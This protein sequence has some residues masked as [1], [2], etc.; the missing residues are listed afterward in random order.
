MSAAISLAWSGLTQPADQQAA[1]ARGS[2]PAGR[3]RSAPPG[4]AREPRPGSAAARSPA[5]RA[6]A[7]R[8]PGRASRCRPGG[9]ARGCAAR[10]RGRGARGSRDS[11]RRSPRGAFRSFA[12]VYPGSSAFTLLCP[13]RTLRGTLARDSRSA[14]GEHC[15]GFAAY[16][17]VPALTPRRPVKQ[18]AGPARRRPSPRR[19]VVEDD[20]VGPDLGARADPHPADHLGAGA[21]ADARARSSARRRRPPRRPSVTQGAIT[22]PGWT[23]TRPSITTCPW[24][25]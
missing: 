2:R 20:R 19:D 15:G 10:A 9:A 12:C 21:D 16:K 6:A 1:A 23:S 13:R 14:S 17:P 24:T 5:R 4:P 22:A 3:R 11:A 25:M 8:W 18:P 7:A